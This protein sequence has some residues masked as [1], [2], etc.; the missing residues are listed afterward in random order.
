MQKSKS[1][2]LT[3]G[4]AVIAGGA[5]AAVVFSLMP[6]SAATFNDSAFGI[7]ATGASPV[8]RTPAVSS[9]DGA[10]HSRSVGTVSSSDQGVLFTVSGLKVS[11][12]AHSASASVDS[13]S[14]IGN[15]VKLQGAIATTCNN[16]QGSV[17]LGGQPVAPGSKQ[18]LSNN[19]VATSNIQTKNADG[20]LTIVGTQLTL[21]T[22]AAPAAVVNL[23]VATCDAG[24]APTTPPSSTS[25][26]STSPTST[27]SPPPTSSTSPTSAPPTS[28][29]SEPPPSTTETAPPPPPPPTTS[30]PVTG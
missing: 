12:A 4:G 3:A 21:T 25:P 14:F 13:G 28:S 20:S 24:A 23:A 30:L 10:P 17:T 19:V 18:Q 5:I 11:A 15:S 27:T 2:A 26:T 7:S 8:S 6:A 29:S 9:S 22:P 16:A 1:T